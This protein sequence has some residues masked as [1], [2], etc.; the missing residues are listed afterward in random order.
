MQ[1]LSHGIFKPANAQAQNDHT[2]N[3]TDGNLIAVAAQTILS[4]SWLSGSN[5][6]YSQTITMPSPYTFDACQIDFRLSTGEVVY[7]GVVKVSSNTY[8]IYTNDNT[9]TYTAV[10]R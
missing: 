10:Y 7:P 3:G 2:H 8:T 5:G 4:A 9:K 1:T 6:R